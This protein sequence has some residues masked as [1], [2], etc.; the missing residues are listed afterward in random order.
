MMD[1]HSETYRREEARREMRG[2]LERFTPPSE[3]LPPAGL[4]PLG[5]LTVALPVPE[6]L[7]YDGFARLLAENGIT[8]ALADRDAQRTALHSG[9]TFEFWPTEEGAARLAIGNV[10]GE[11]DAE[12]GSRFQQA[13]WLVSLLNQALPEMGQRAAEERLEARL[14]AI[15]ASLGDRETVDLGAAIASLKAAGFDVTILSGA[16]SG[17]SAHLFRAPDINYHFHSSEALVAYARSLAQ[18]QDGAAEGAVRGQAPIAA[19]QSIV[20]RKAGPK[21]LIPFYLLAIAL[22]LAYAAYRWLI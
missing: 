2:A 12:T 13:A 3:H 16:Q 9:V 10:I 5:T 19:R 17:F 15:T 4:S 21:R 20:T 14:Q 1:F 6:T 11:S 22:V 18:P 8:P 7:A